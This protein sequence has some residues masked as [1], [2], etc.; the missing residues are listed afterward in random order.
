M[1]TRDAQT[2]T[3][4]LGDGNLACAYSV[5]KVLDTALGRTYGTNPDYVPSVVSDLQRNAERIAP[6]DVKPGDIAVRLPGEGER[7]GHIGFVVS[8]GTPPE[9]LSNSSAHKSFTSV[10]D[11]AAFGKNYMG[12]GEDPVAYYR[13][14]PKTVNLEWVRAHPVPDAAH[15]LG[16]DKAPLDP[17]HWSEHLPGT[18]AATPA[19]TVPPATAAPASTPPANALPGI[20]FG[21]E[22]TAAAERHHLDPTLLGAVAAQETGG[23]GALQGR[24]IVGDHGHGHGIMQIGRPLAFVRVDA[25]RN[26][27]GAKRRVRSADDAGLNRS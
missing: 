18:A 6:G 16:P 5:N 23:P 26:G 4:A 15:A 25:G 14:D 22:I 13:I 10:Q 1:S 27:P 17:T 19:A 2:Q 20:A 8:D 12:H 3:P 21:R 9:I 24:N 11:A 7:H